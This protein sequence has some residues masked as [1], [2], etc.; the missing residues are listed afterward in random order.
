MLFGQC[1]KIDVEFMPLY[2]YKCDACGHQFE[3]IQ[4]FSDPLASTCPECGAAVRKLVSSPAFQLK[5]TGWYA[6]DFA[7][8]PGADK[9]DSSKEESAST[10]KD[11]SDASDTSKKKDSGDKK[12]GDSKSTQTPSSTKSSPTAAP[13]K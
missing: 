1:T 11:S 3:L 4:K 2:E 12:T 5:G 13:K 8:K 10:K 9:K 7:G 6:T